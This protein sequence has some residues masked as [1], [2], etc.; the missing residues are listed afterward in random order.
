MRVEVKG[1][2]DYLLS[3]INRT[4]GGILRMRLVRIFS[5]SWMGRYKKPLSLPI[6]LVLSLLKTLT[7]FQGALF[8]KTAPWTPTKTFYKDGF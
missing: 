3:T 1:S 2:F 6:Q 7:I 4:G 5:A 8:E